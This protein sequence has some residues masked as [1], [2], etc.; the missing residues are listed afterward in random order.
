MA[1]EMLAKFH[2]VKHRKEEALDAL[3]RCKHEPDLT[4]YQQ[5]NILAYKCEAAFCKEPVDSALFMTNYIELQKMIK[6]TGKNSEF[7]TS[8]DIHYAEVTGQYDRM[9]E[10]ARQKPDKIQRYKNIYKAYQK[11][12]L[13]CWS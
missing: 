3:D 4:P 1:D 2:L 13:Q 10:L 5:M 6:D 7:F 11:M 12:G 8:Q 9:L